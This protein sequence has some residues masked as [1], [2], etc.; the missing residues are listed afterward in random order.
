MTYHDAFEISVEFFSKI[1]EKCK[2]QGVTFCIEP[3][4]AVYGADFIR[5][6]KES[7]ALIAKVN[8]TALKLNMD[9]G[10]LLVNKEP[11][12]ETI[13]QNSSHI[14]HIHIS[15]PYLRQINRDYEFHKGISDVLNE[16]GYSDVI[17]IEML[18][19]PIDNSDCVLQTL[20][21]VSELYT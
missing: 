12:K 8:S 19:Q 20:L 11:I 7:V 10:S 5:N 2:E 15:E 6:I 13:L 9:I 16:C 14:G 1:A 17:S 4:P 3:T 18:P 21:F